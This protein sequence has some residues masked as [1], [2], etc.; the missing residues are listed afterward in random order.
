MG[1]AL[2][3]ATG[4]TEVIVL[5]GLHAEYAAEPADRLWVTLADREAEDT[6]TP[7][8]EVADRDPL[9]YLYTSGTTSFPKGVVASHLAIYLESMS[10][11]L[12]SGWSAADRFVGHDAD[13]PHR[14]AQRVLHAR[15][16]RRR[17]HPRAARLRSRRRCS[18]SSSASAS[19]R[20]SGCR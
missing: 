14:P 13:V 15:R 7:T 8:A 10:T 1:D 16:A 20:C 5:P 12:D 2:R 6:Y 4:V 17:H 19:R 3:K 18:T 9:T 11:A